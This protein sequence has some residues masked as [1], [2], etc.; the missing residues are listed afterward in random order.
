MPKTCGE[1]VELLSISGWI[2]RVD[3]STVSQLDR[4]A[5]TTTWVQPLDILKFSYSYTQQFYLYLKQ[6]LLLAE[7]DLYPVS[8]APIIRATNLKNLKER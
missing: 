7:Q 2:S 4:L 1:V 5:S 6:S 3:S 8:T